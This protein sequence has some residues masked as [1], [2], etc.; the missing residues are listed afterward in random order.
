MS[1]ILALSALLAPAIAFGAAATSAHASDGCDF[2]TLN[3]NG[4][5]MAYENCEGAVTIEY[6]RPRSTMRRQGVRSGT[7][8][9]RGWARNG[10][11]SGTAYR[12]KAGCGRIGYSVSGRQRAYGATLIGTAPVR[13]SG[14]GVTRYRRDVLR[15]N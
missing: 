10:R 2:Q 5:T 13:G 15:F 14:C 1:R 7:V 9:F 12:F 8:L 3:H 11:I 6:T 4:S